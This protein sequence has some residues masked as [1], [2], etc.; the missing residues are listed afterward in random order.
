MN[1]AQTKVEKIRELLA[2]LEREISEAR[3]ILRGQK[4][5]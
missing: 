4:H 1:E 5:E 3:E 2:D